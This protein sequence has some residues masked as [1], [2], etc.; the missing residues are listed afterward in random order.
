MR[1]ILSSLGIRLAEAWKNA[2]Q[3]TEPT[4]EELPADRSEAYFVQDEMAHALDEDLSGWKVG[5]TSAKMRELDGHDG[6]IP[7]R[8]FKSVTWH[9]TKSGPA[10]QP[11]S[12]CA[13]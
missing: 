11:F 3:I 8:I 4:P 6:V 10:S 7:G 2:S 5:A 13:S 1:K 12:G 9:G